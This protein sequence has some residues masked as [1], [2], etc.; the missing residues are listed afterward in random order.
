MQKRKA[1]LF[2]LVLSFLLSPILLSANPPIPAVK[3]QETSAPS[4]V[5]SE[6]SSFDPQ[7]LVDYPSAGYLTWNTT[8]GLYTMDKSRWWFSFTDRCNIKQIEKAV[9]W[10]NT[11]DTVDIAKIANVKVTIANNTV[12]QVLYSCVYKGGGLAKDTVIG[13]FTVTHYFNKE[14]K[15]KIT[16]ELQRDEVAWGEAG[17]GDFNIAWVLLPTKTYI[18]INEYEAVTLPD[19]DTVKI[20]ETILKEDKKCEVGSSSNPAEWTGSWSLTFWDDVEGACVLY[21]GAEKVWGGKGITVVFPANETYIDP[22][23]VA[24]DINYKAASYPFQRKGFYAAERFWAFYSDGTWGTYESTADPTD[25]SGSTTSIGICQ[26]GTLLSARFDGTYVHYARFYSYDLFYRRGTPNGDGAIT[27]SAD[28]QLVHE[29][30]QYDEYDFPCLTVDSNGYVWIGVRYRSGLSTY[31]PYVLKNANNN[32]TWSTDFAYPLSTP[33]ASTCKTQPIALT[34]GKVYVMYYFDGNLPLGQLYTGSWGSEESDLADHP[35]GNSYGLSAVNEGDDVHFTYNRK[36]TYQIR[37]NKRTYGVGWEANDV[38]VQDSMETS[39][40]PA[41]S[42]DMASGDLY[43]FWLRTDTDHVYYKTCVSGTW[44]TDPTDWIDESADQILYGSMLNSFYQAYGNYIGLLYVTSIPGPHNLRFAYLTTTV[45]T[46]PTIGEFQ[47]A[48][49]YANKYAY[50]NITIQDADGNTTFRNSTIGLM[51]A[52]YTWTNATNTFSETVSQSYMQLDTSGSLRIYINSTAFK[53]SFK[54]KFFWNATEGPVN[55]WGIIY[56]DF[57][58]SATHQETALFTFEDDLIIHTDT[59]VDE[60]IVDPSQTITFTASIYY[61]GTSIVPEDVTGITAYVELDGVEKGLDTD[62]TGGLSITI[63][64]ES[65]IT[66]YSYNIYATTDQNTVQNQTVNVTVHFITKA[67]RSYNN[68]LQSEGKPY[69]QNSTYLI[70]YLSYTPSELTFKVDVPAGNVSETVA[71]SIGR[72][73]LNV[74]ING[75]ASYPKSTRADYD[76]Y[77]G[78]CWYYDSA[79]DLIY[80]KTKGSTVH[81]VWEGY[82]PPPPVDTYPPP[83]P[84][85]PQLYDVKIN[86]A[87]FMVIYPFQRS[88]TVKVIIV[89]PTALT[90]D[91]VLQWQLLDQQ[92]RT[93]IQGTQVIMV[94]AYG[95]VTTTINIPT[96]ITLSQ[97]YTVVTQTTAPLQSTQATQTIRVT[98]IPTWLIITFILLIIIIIYVKQ[99]KR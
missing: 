11:T 63:T 50:V 3:A 78:N 68:Q 10:I 8:F 37:Y 96:P 79:N 83:P 40:A 95:N 60:S 72:I 35:L 93:V 92:N 12:L 36:A 94:P 25:W 53:L 48:T 38:L 4:T 52:N 22:S 73:P 56:D 55:V 19:A 21:A 85:P 26:D 97:T 59:T 6:F 90:A 57:D 46:A 80:I 76:A 16:V 82:T 91:A 31:T 41:L 51:G 24:T 43:C 81:A 34:D 33:L 84:P 58:A 27:W 54:I 77:Q 32:G 14:Q 30:A 47:A 23:T 86:D 20:K 7:L 1:L 29:G 2:L 61:E 98:S 88:F 15:P 42:I 39:S 65:V 44:D 71:A 49:V 13:N 45:N 75:L 67:Y 9:F 62:V 28:E 74:Y 70:T 69:I 18:K 17:L 87:P 99:K 64:A 5:W 66:Q 89:N